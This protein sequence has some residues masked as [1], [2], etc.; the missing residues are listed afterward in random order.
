MDTPVTK[1]KDLQVFVGTSNFKFKIHERTMNEYK[2]AILRIEVQ[3]P[4]AAR[5]FNIYEPQSKK[6][7]E[8]NPVANILYNAKLTYYEGN[9]SWSLTPL[10]KCAS[11]DSQEPQE[12]S[13]ILTITRHKDLPVQLRT[14]FATLCE[15]QLPDTS[16]AFPYLVITID[17][18]SHNI[19]V[20]QSANGKDLDNKIVTFKLVESKKKRKLKIISIENPITEVEPTPVIGLVA[21]AIWLDSSKTKHQIA[22]VTKSYDTTIVDYFSPLKDRRYEIPVEH[23]LQLFTFE[24]SPWYTNIPLR[25]VLAWN[26]IQETSIVR[27]L[28]YSPEDGCMPDYDLGDFLDPKNLTPLTPEEVQEMIYDPN[29]VGTNNV[30]PEPIEVDEDEIPF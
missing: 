13:D 29:Y 16:E 15:L 21:G 14:E 3:T 11:K 7:K 28:G 23:F 8:L 9:D 20:P 18:E 22:C 26:S 24:D 12:V 10:K 19:L 2:T 30:K 17:G 1:I 25:G 5:T 27:I 4:R 6:W